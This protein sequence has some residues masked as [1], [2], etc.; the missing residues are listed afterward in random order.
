MHLK[1]RANLTL[2]KQEKKMK[3]EKKTKKKK[4]PALE[5]KTRRSV[6]RL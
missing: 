3:E 6:D 4:T 5:E 1:L 2:K